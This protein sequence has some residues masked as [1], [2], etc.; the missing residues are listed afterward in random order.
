MRTY[1]YYTV[2]VFTKR[3]FGGN[4]L[5]VFPEAQGIDDATMQA[6]A[7]ELNYSETTFVLPP[8]DPANTANVRIFNRKHEMP[9]VGHPNV[10]TAFVLAQ[11]GRANEGMLRFEEISGRVD[12]QLSK[13]AGAVIGATIDAPQPLQ[14]LTSL[15]VPEIAACLSIAA[16][17]INV[18]EHPPVVA[19][20]GIAFTLVAVSAASLAAASPDLSAYRRLVA[21][22]PD[23][24]GRLSILLYTP[25]GP[26][27]GRDI[28]ARM[29]A[30]L[31]NTWEDPATGSA[32]AALAAFRLSLSE[33]AETL[34]Y[35]AIQGVEMG[36]E[37]HMELRAWRAADGI[38]ASV[39]GKCVSVFHGSIDL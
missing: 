4:Q 21:A 38:R 24:G 33:D 7:T 1:E 27:A 5:A 3:R 23:L 35:N 36:R 34:H 12:V 29:F 10:G 31:A 6:L 26:D 15:P 32:N 8:K 19:S 16:A 17:D 28:R 25:A 18:I 39:G 2:D 14:I 11:C 13:E 37:S 22:R 20:V 30:P 9:F